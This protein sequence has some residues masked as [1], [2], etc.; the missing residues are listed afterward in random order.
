[1][2]DWRITKVAQDGTH[3]LFEGRPIY[4]ARFREVLK[5][6]APGLAA[7]LGDDGAWHIDVDGCSAYSERHVR[8]FGFYEDRAAVEGADG[9]F[10]VLPDGSPLQA[11][12]YSWCGNF[13]EGRCVV[14][15][16]GGR[17]FHVALN[18]GDAYAERHLYAGDFRDD[19][20]VVRHRADGLCG[21]IDP[22]GHQIHGTRLLD[23]DVY[24]KGYARARDPA[25]WFHVDRAGRP[26]YARRFFGVEPFYNGTAL[27]WTTAGTRVLIDQRG[28]T[29][30]EIADFRGRLSAS[31]AQPKVLV[32]GNVGAGKSTLVSALAARREWRSASI[33]ASRRTHGDGSA[34][35]EL[36]AWAAFVS[37]ARSAGPLLLECTGVGPQIPLLRLALRSSGDKIG[38]LWLRAPIDVCRTRVTGRPS[39][40]PYPDFG[41]AIGQVVADLEQH[42]SAAMAPNGTWHRDLIDELDG[43]AP[44]DALVA[45][46]DSLIDAW[47]RSEPHAPS[48]AARG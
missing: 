28:E 12:R 16:A 18:G 1:M 40:P 19:A 30:H 43:T 6:H 22:S 23:L 46:A 42:L 41:V 15:D 2:T 11:D 29:R 17:Y 5:F 20:A 31:S 27:A 9:W 39:P 44:L 21:H 34:D 38:V 47:E 35:G 37:A 25:G 8:T 7:V 33:D 10:H 45:R 3:H 13:Q 4:A 48:D 32:L 14:R 24:H 36:R 26:A